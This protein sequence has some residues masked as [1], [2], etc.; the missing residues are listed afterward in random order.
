MFIIFNIIENYL[1]LTCNRTCFTVAP[2]HLARYTV[3]HL[4]QISEQILENSIIL[5]WIE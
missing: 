1:I 2:E 5:F 4:Y 3:E